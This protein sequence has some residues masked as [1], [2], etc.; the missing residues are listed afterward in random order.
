V[1]PCG[2]EAVSF[3]RPRPLL[4]FLFDTT[5]AVINLALSGVLARYPAIR[6]VVPHAGAALPVIADRVDRFHPWIGLPADPPV[7]V[8]AALG[9]LHYDLAGVP[10]P[11][12]L[13]ALLGL[14]GPGQ[15]VYG[16]DYP[17]TPADRV[18]PLASAIASAGVLNDQAL[19]AVLRGNA[20]RLLP[21][22]AG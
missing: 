2:W 12:A 14:V 16:S 1:S 4:E 19:A 9:R 6:W 15:L 11:R 3:G 13:P 7:D 17:F 5:R 22:F 20:L 21:R 18:R 8:I 10:L